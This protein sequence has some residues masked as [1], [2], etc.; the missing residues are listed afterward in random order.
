MSAKLQFK[1]TC[2]Q[3]LSGRFDELASG[4]GLGSYPFDESLLLVRFL[5]GEVSEDSLS[6]ASDDK[7]ERTSRGRK[8]EAYFYIAVRHLIEGR[9]EKTRDC[10]AKC[11]ETGLSAFMEYKA[12]EA[13]LKR[14]EHDK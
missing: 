14:L 1:R 8:C 4:G 3:R 13:E 9:K 10:L 11:L 7:D 5:L 6:R 12:A 2:I